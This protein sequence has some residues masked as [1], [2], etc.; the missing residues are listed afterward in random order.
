MSIFSRA[1]IVLSGVVSVWIVMKVHEEQENDRLRLH[2]GVIMDEER[3]AKKRQNIA[4]L[5]EQA[6]LREYLESTKT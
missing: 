2:Q 1:A 5:K 4:E 6:K 3:Q